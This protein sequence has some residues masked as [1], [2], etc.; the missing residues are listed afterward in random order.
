M[1]G[2]FTSAPAE[3]TV[4]STW[5]PN[6]YKPVKGQ[7]TRNGIPDGTPKNPGNKKALDNQGLEKNS[8]GEGGIRTLGTFQY[9]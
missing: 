7:L 1:L 9:A 4:T 5:N 8:G 2:N 6:L 3:P